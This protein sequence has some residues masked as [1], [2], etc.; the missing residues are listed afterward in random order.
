MKIA[1]L[2]AAPLMLAA[3]GGTTPA[4][5]ASAP[6]SDAATANAAEPVDHA[7]M[8]HGDMAHMANGA[9]AAAGNVTTPA[10]ELDRAMAAMHSDMG[11]A[12]GDVDIDFMRMMIPHHQGAIDMAR[13]AQRHGT[14]PEVRR[15][16]DE[17]VAAQERE[18]AQMQAWLERRGAA[19]R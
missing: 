4:E 3:C 19:A 9:E 15:L 11:T 7:A 14:D 12:T 2:L 18:I 10:Q 17:V 16:A 5:N 6:A 8:G 1:A 13:I